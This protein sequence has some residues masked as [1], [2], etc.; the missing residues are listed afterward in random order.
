MVPK[1]IQL[2]SGKEKVIALSLFARECVTASAV[3]SKLDANVFETDQS[4][5]PL[6]SNGIFWSLSHKPGYVAG[7][8]SRQRV[9][10]DIEQLKPVSDDVFK[11]IVDPIESL[12]FVNQ[13]KMLVFFRIFTAKEAVLKKERLGFKGLSKI[14]IHEVLDDTHLIVQYLDK[15]YQVENFYFDGGLASVTK[16]NEDIEWSFR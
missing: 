12:H 9:G 14:K 5:A 6:P 2:L 8:V 13:E 16:E 1:A 3:K 11:R 4:G 15:K 10:I 7:V